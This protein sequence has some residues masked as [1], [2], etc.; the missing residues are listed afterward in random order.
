MKTPPADLTSNRRYRKSPRMLS[1]LLIALAA[2][3]TGCVRTT[4]R[5]GMMP[6]E[7]ALGWDERWNHAF[8]LGLVQSS[9]PVFPERICKKG[10]AEL[11]SALDPLQTAIAIVTLGIYTPT[12]ISVICHA[13]ERL[14]R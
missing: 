11:E 13:E 5:S 10:W 4:I 7:P 12:T 8:L 9:G 2:Q 1:Y 3:A 14:P 6:G